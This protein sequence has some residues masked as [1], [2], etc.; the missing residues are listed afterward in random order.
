MNLTI[1]LWDLIKSI[2]FNSDIAALTKLAEAP[3]LSCLTATSFETSDIKP[4]YT[5]PNSPD[6]RQVL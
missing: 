4:L 5:I 2:T 3:F 6:P 1:F